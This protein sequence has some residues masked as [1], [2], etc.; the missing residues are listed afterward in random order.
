[1]KKSRYYNGQSA[2]K[3][4]SFNNMRKVQRLT[5]DYGVELSS[6]KWEALYNNKGE[7]IVYSCKR[8]QAGVIPDRKVTNPCEYQVWDLSA[9]ILNA[10]FINLD[11][12]RDNIIVVTEYHSIFDPIANEYKIE[13]PAGKMLDEKFKPDSYYDYLFYTHYVDDDTIDFKD[14]F[15]FVTTRYSKYPARTGGGGFSEA[16]IPNNLQMLIDPVRAYYNIV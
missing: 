8:L 3:P 1:M 4:L 13:I 7:D 15:K 16:L 12:L 2:A 5:V 11:R 9:N 6:S 10:F 14:R